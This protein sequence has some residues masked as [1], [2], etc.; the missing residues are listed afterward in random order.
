MKRKYLAIILFLLI[1]LSFTLGQSLEL[2]G[3]KVFFGSSMSEQ[4]NNFWQ[5]NGQLESEYSYIEVYESDNVNGFFYKNQL[6]TLYVNAWDNNPYP[7]CEEI[8]NLITNVTPYKQYTEF[9]E[10]GIFVELY[11]TNDFYICRKSSRMNTEYIIIPVTLL[12]KI[13]TE[14][15]DYYKECFPD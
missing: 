15:P 14:H 12:E 7:V 13:Q 5:N 3:Q 6:V 2:F 4:K 11:K 9:D 10:V 8:E 1:P